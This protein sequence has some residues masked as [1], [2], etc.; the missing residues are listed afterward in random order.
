MVGLDE[1]LR[2]AD[3]VSINLALNAE[4]KH[5]I[6]MERLALMKSSAI[7]INVATPEHM[8]TN[9][10]VEAL[11][12]GRIG[13]AGLDGVDGIIKGHPIFDCDNVVLAP[14][15]GSFTSESFLKNL[16]EIVTV[17]VE[18]FLKGTPINCVN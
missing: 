6:S 4:T 2:S 12:D 8:D 5:I 11:K 18:N 13:G 17:G 3:I 15:V 7:L 9:A 14:H 1:L 10:L 16:P